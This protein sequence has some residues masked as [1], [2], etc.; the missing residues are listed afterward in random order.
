VL[1][2]GEWNLLTWWGNFL[3]NRIDGIKANPWEMFVK[4]QVNESGSGSSPIAILL[5]GD[6]D[7]LCLVLGGKR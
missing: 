1:V 3:E 5:I 2:E 6:F 7:L 4:L